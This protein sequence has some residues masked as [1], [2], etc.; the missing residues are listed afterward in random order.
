VIIV[1]AF[2]LLGVA[3]AGAVP[4]TE[5]SSPPPADAAKAI[6]RPEGARTP[7]IALMKLVEVTEIGGKIGDGGFD[8]RVK[9]G[10]WLAAELWD[11]G[12]HVDRVGRAWAAE[13]ELAVLKQVVEAGRTLHH[14]GETELEGFFELRYRLRRDPDEATLA[15]YFYDRS[16]SASDPQLG[17]F[18][19]YELKVLAD[20]LKE[21]MECAVSH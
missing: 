18:D 15:F 3:C 14:F 19:G 20:R 13:H 2:V 9:G 21:A 8:A 16:G 11:C 4:Q 1:A 6:S 5:S 7:V 17:A 12:G 10:T